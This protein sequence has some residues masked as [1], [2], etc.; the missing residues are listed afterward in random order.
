MHS[1][2]G[3]FFLAAG[4]RWC[5]DP[6]TRPARNAPRRDAKLSRGADHRLLEATHVPGDVAPDL[7]EIYDRVAHDLARPVVRNVA[8]AVGFK[9][10]NF[11]LAQHVIGGAQIRQFSVAAE[12][13]HVRMLA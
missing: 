12:R 10:R 7:G 6:H 8:A 9:K 3:Q 13:D 5:I 2:C 11:H 1:D 4:F